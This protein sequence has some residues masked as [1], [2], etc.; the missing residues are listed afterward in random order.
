MIENPQVLANLQPGEM[1]SVRG[2][3][4]GKATETGAMQPTYRV[5]GVQR[6]RK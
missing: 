4:F 5:S 1:V 2:R 6:Q 3:L